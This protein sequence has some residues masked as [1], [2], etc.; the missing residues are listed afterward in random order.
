M[1][2]CAAGV[3]RF[4]I[5]SGV[6]VFPQRVQLQLQGNTSRQ[7]IART[8]VEAYPAARFVFVALVE[9]CLPVQIS[10]PGCA[11]AERAAVEGTEDRVGGAAARLQRALGHFAVVVY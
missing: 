4:G 10:K 3:V 11:L 2:E 8:D 6:P 7:W 5:G 9:R 1:H